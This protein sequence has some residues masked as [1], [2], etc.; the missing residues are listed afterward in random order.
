MITIFSVIV[1]L[2]AMLLL[3]Q[4]GALIE[5]FEQL[6]QV[7]SYLDMEDNP[8][9]LDLG[10]SV[11]MTPSALGLPATLDDAEAA[12]VLFL[13]DK[14]ST[15]VTLATE[16]QQ[17]GLPETMWLVVVPVMGDGARFVATFGLSGDRVLIDPDHAITE[18]IGIDLTPVALL[19]ESGRLSA[20]QTVPTTRQMYAA[21]SEHGSRPGRPFSRA[22]GS[23]R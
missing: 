23:R 18:A 2:L 9:P 21:I 22:T 19:V 17:A 4:F 5:M 16:L 6:K 14:C 20:L 15:C 7:R 1:G 11:G 8:H 12:V 13:S 3:V 10:D